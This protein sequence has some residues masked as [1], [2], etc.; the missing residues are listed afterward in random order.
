MII[1]FL[2]FVILTLLVEPSVVYGLI[3]ANPLPYPVSMVWVDTGSAVYFPQNVEKIRILTSASNIR[4]KN[5]LLQAVDRSLQRIYSEKWVPVALPGPPPKYKSQPPE[6]ELL[7]SSLVTSG[8]PKTSTAAVR[9][10]PVSTKRPEEPILTETDQVYVSIVSLRK[11]VSATNKLLSKKPRVSKAFRPLKKSIVKQGQMLKKRAADSPQQILA[12]GN[13]K[14]SPYTLNKHISLI[15]LTIADSNIELNHGVNETYT[16]K[17]THDA[18]SISSATTW[19]ALHALSTLEQLVEW[20]TAAKSLFIEQTVTINDQPLYAYRGVMI[21]TA[22][23]FYDIKTLKRQIDAMALS[24]INVFH[25]HLVDTQSWPVKLASYPQMSQDAYSSSEIYGVEEMQDIVSYSY[26][27]GVRVIPEIDMPAHS[28]SGWRKIKPDLVSCGESFWNGFDNN[29]QLHTAMQPTPGHLDIMHP[30]VL[31]IVGKI[32]NELSGIFKDDFFHVGM[33]EIVPN[34]YNFSSYVTKWFKENNERT[35]HDLIQSWV[36]RTM[37]MYLEHRPN[38]KVMMWEDVVTSATSS[39]YNISTADVVIQSWIN[40][41][42]G[43]K[44]ILQDGY[45]VIVSSSDFFYLDCGSGGFV[46]DDPRYDVQENPTPDQDSF[47]YQGPGGSW[48]APYKTWQ[49]IY[50]Y[51]FPEVKYTKTERPGKILG[52]S[53]QL[54]SEQS[55]ANVIDAK[56]WPR[57]ASLAELLWS[58]NKQPDNPAVKRLGEFAQRIVNFRERLVARGI[59]AEALMPRYCITRPHSCDLNMMVNGK[60]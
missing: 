7:K 37:P 40:G 42:S 60:Y 11:Q 18:V 5:L 25:W 32:Y 50:S 17:I 34:C 35:Y 13:P 15:N 43:I 52:G 2:Q 26:E 28:N 54:W 59:R 58:G 4:H 45:D 3:R 33:D 12:P 1:Y 56:I 19:G 53:V 41:K 38:R 22:R 57:A 36:D 31:E 21:D 24:K 47:N 8:I 10:L 44:Q 20:D 16:L 27:R 46:T 29:W 49:R 39:A 55:D 51:D 23:N 30:E 14:P 9:N 48:C 6:S